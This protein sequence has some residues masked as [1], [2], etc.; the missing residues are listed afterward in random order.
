M[1]DPRPG[2]DPRAA[3]LPQTYHELLDLLPDEAG[4]AASRSCTRRVIAAR[5]ALAAAEQELAEAVRAAYD[6][7]D[8][9]LTIGTVWGISRQAAQQRFGR[10]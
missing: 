7:G 10:R 1:P 4:M 8:S 5:N 6:R 3:R 2:P 9:W